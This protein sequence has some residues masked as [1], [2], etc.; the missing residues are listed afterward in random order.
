[1]ID[2]LAAEVEHRQ[3]ETAA[4]AETVLENLWVDGERPVDLG[5]DER[6]DDQ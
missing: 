1:M 6:R 3:P 4:E 2:L 5:D